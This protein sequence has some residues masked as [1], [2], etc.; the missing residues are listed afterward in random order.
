MH[1]LNETITIF[2]GFSRNKNVSES[3][4]GN[5]ILAAYISDTSKDAILKNHF[6]SPLFSALKINKASKVIFP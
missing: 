6:L 1:V 2:I 5:E 4:Y 3:D